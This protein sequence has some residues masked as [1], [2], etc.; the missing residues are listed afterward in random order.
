[1]LLERSPKRFL[2]W[3]RDIMLVLSR[4]VGESVRVSD[5]IRIYVVAVEGGRVRLG[6]EAPQ[7]VKIIRSELEVQVA[8]ANKAAAMPLSK[9]KGGLLGKAAAV[10][11]AST[12]KG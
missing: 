5:D 11:S 4:K 6:I 7:S 12:K 10:Q 1:M 2:T 9:L 8:D 3:G